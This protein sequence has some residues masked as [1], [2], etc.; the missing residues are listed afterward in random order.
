MIAS[1]DDQNLRHSVLGL[2]CSTAVGVG[3][4][5]L[6]AFAGGALQLALWGLA[7]LLDLGGPFLF[8]IEGW[9]LVPGHFAERH[10]AIVI[11]ALGESIVA[12]G[13]G[14]RPTIAAGVVIAAVLGVVIA[15]ALWWT[16]FDVVA[17]IAARRLARAAEGRERNEIARDSYSYLHFP[18]IAGIAL[19]AV[20]I[21]RAL[22]IGVDERLELVPAVALLGGA[23]MYML[24]HVAFRLRNMHTLSGRRLVC[25]V[26]L[27]ALVPAGAALPALATIA[28]V[29]A[30][31]VALVAYEAL[32][33]ADVRDRVRHQP[34]GEGVPS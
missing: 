2:A 31:L 11:I 33:Y 23:A 25:A 18:M 12:I 22:M 21:K 6:A 16:Y 27:L 1:R 9:K 13:I 7:L 19:I 10:G 26:V 30:V 24:A 34:A 20:G 4:L 28:I 32:R 17:I 3:L 29:A 15:A 14:A 5:I 8:G